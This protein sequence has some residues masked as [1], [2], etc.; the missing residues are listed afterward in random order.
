MTPAE[1]RALARL[2]RSAG[3]LTPEVEAALR[4]SFAQ[5]RA[6]IGEQA[7][8]QAIADGSYE[9]LIAEVLSDASTWQAYGPVREQIARGVERVARTTTAG[10]PPRVVQ[11]VGVTFDTLAP[12]VVDAIRTLQTTQVDALA[13]GLRA[14][15][16]QHIQ[17]GVE[18]G[19]GPRTIARGLREVVP[20]A[21][22]QELAI[23]NYAHALREGQRGK[24]LGYR[25]RDKRFD[26]TVRAGTLTPERIDRMVAAYRQK[27]VNYNALTHARTAA[28]ES[29]RVGQQLA[30]QQA[31]EAG[32]QAGVRFVKRWVHNSLRDP[33]PEH[34]ALDGTAVDVEAL[35]PNGDAYPGQQDPWNCRC[36]EVYEMQALARA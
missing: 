26:A 20:L 35:Y 6:L 15:F 1:R 21:P 8:A 12:Q 14:T 9:R 16:R 33:R 2:T 19:Q 22:N 34:K 17:A 30:W 31:A 36:T 23:R 25:L 7:W 29:H 13:E 4:A 10:L 5:V 11:R 24:A 32:A 28:L 27:M 18:A 3:R